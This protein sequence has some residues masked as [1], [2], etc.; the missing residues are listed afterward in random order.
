MIDNAYEDARPEP[1][2][3]D[4]D[5]DWKPKPKRIVK[6]DVE[7]R[8]PGGERITYERATVLNER[9]YRLDPSDERGRRK[10]CHASLKL[11]TGE[12]VMIPDS[13]IAGWFPRSNR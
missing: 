5:D 8:L 12:F 3:R 1:Q 2:Q 10:I 6:V 7:R 13:E 9:V 11:V 4:R